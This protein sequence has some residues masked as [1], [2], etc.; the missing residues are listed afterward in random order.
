MHAERQQRV[1]RGPR[2]TVDTSGKVVLKLP[3]QGL[4]THKLVVDYLGGADF[5]AAGKK[6]TWRVVQ[7]VATA[8]RGRRARAEPGPARSHANAYQAIRPSDWAQTI[9]RTRE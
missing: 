8:R 6:V 3:K 2:G 5:E 7:E 4:G 1:R 9:G